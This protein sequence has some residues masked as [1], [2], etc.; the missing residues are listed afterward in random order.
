[1][2]GCLMLII[3]GFLG[4]GAWYLLTVHLFSVGD[5]AS[6]VI[7]AVM[8]ILAFFIVQKIKHKLKQ[9]MGI[10]ERC[11]HCGGKLDSFESECV[12][13]KKPTLETIKSSIAS[14]KEC[15]PANCPFCKTRITPYLDSSTLNIKYE[16]CC[17]EFKAYF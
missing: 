8:L 2:G 13:C 17:S 14:I 12:D 15:K 4:A 10:D 9:L 11:R 5:F 6:L 3:V 16:I 7:L 1:M